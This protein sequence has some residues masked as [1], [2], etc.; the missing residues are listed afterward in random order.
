M[1]RRRPSIEC[2]KEPVTWINGNLMRTRLGRFNYM[3]SNSWLDIIQMNVIQNWLCDLFGTILCFQ[4]LPFFDFIFV[5][6]TF[7]WA[8]ILRLNRTSI[9]ITK[10]SLND[11]AWLKMHLI[12]TYSSPVFASSSSS[13]SMTTGLDASD[14]SYA[15]GS[16]KP[17]KSS[18]IS[19]I[20]QNALVYFSDG[21]LQFPIFFGEM[22]IVQ[23]TAILTTLFQ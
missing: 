19:A 13:S 5:V 10:N 4:F 11:F 23:Q 8:L 14:V 2:L 3:N 18:S 9:N 1:L 21:I 7:D 16:S 20:F 15:I 6:T 17:P 12:S 22:K